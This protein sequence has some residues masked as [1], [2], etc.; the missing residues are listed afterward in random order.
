V[1]NYPTSKYSADST[2]NLVY[3]Y[4]LDSRYQEA[5]EY[6]N[7]SIEKELVE[8]ENLEI[9]KIL[10]ESYY[11]LGEIHYSGKQY[12]LAAQNFLASVDYFK[13]ISA[14]FPDTNEAFVAKYK[15]PELLY[16]AAESHK[17]TK[18][19]DDAIEILDELK[20]IYPDS[21]YYKSAENLLYYIY[22]MKSG[23]LKADGRSGESIEVL[24][25]VLEL[26]S[27]SL[28]YNKY[29][30]KS[31]LFSL[32]QGIRETV[33]IETADRLFLQGKNSQA[34]FIYGYVYEKYPDFRQTIIMNYID[35]NIRIA[36][37]ESNT[38]LETL[39]QT[40]PTGFIGKE[41]FAKVSFENKTGFQI[42]IFIKG[43]EY[44]ILELDNELKTE[45]DLTA[46]NYSI[47]VL[48]SEEGARPFYGELLYED[49]ARYR[50]VFNSDS[51]VNN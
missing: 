11:K 4:Y 2:K 12:E 26:D 47:L 37:A 3:S 17:N 23:E 28:N 8:S 7:L 1:K 15:V 30:V 14:K 51:D 35:C 34:L 16:K 44:E 32:L 40:E 43:P 46:G 18:Q 21:E 25:K 13:E 27:E 24:V 10:S 38:S 29:Q 22:I 42:I 6:F 33:I 48:P 50:E 19:W 31:R 20:A 41:G 39:L 49:G 5:I 9:K 45:L 36:L